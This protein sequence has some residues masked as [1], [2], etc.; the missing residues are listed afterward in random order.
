MKNILLL[1]GF[2]SLFSC[3]KEFENCIR[4]TGSI[5][6]ETRP[7]ASFENIEVNDNLNLTWFQSDSSYLK[8]KAGKNLIG[9]LTSRI[10]EKTLIL[11]NENTCNWTRSYRIPVEIE[12]HSPPPFL[13]RQL[14][15]GKIQSIDT[16]TATPLTIQ[17]YGAGDFNLL[18]HGGEL[19]VDF[20]S[21]GTCLLSG[22]ADIGAYSTQNFGKLDASKLNIAQCE[23]NMEGENDAK[24]WVSKLL[25][26]K[27]KSSRAL[28][29]KGNPIQ[30]IDFLSTGKI[31]PIP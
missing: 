16:L 18:V 28:F 30:Q 9:Q 4:S 2:V 7:L 15:F 5:G 26:G 19:Y 22:S 3:K 8:I 12:L 21:P 20:N 31:I 23:L 11:K 1:M 10:S 27:H 17:Q 13:I 25:T 29:L 6:A 14:G 24:I